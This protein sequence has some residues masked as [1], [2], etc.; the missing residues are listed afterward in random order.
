MPL[1][2]DFIFSQHS[3]QDFV[4]CPRR[5]Q[6]RYVEKILWPA[7]LTEPVLEQEKRMLLGASFHRCVQQHLNGIPAEQIA[8]QIDDPIL[9]SWWKRF[10]Q[11][12]PHLP[13]SEYWVEHM[14]SIRLGAYRCVAR[15]DLIIR[16]DQENIIIDWKT[17]DRIPKRDKI[18]GRLQT[19]LYPF[20][21]SKLRHLSASTR[22]DPDHL[23]MKYWFVNFPE[24]PFAVMYSKEKFEQ[25]EKYLSNL[26]ERIQTL[27]EQDFEM[28]LDTAKCKFCNYRSLCDRGMK[29]GNLDELEDDEFTPETDSLDIDQIGEITL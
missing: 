9:E 24:T 23:V 15:Y 17:A 4:D 5:F 8:A 12:Q 2:D 29:A 7:P 13:S 19:I 18:E 25:D 28:T 22:I 14:L 6:L 11:F 3:L 16:N 21:L 27:T 1:P 26:V 20:L 10:V